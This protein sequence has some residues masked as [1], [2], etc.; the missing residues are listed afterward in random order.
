MSF[1]VI[2]L[3]YAE[4]LDRAFLALNDMKKSFVTAF[5]D[6]V[7]SDANM[8]VIANDRLVCEFSD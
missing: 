4:S 7:N 6:V 5:C 8:G 3:L 1:R 2:I